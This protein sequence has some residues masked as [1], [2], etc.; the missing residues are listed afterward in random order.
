MF[1]EFPARND[2]MIVDKGRNYD[3]HNVNNRTS[4]VHNENQT[5]LFYFFNPFRNG[6][7]F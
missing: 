4:G 7:F 6:R 3:N 2:E 1:K 5:I